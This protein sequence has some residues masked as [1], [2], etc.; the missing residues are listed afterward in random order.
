[1]LWLRAQTYRSTNESHPD[2]ASDQI[3]YGRRGKS[4]QECAAEV[5]RQRKFPIAFEYLHGRT[6]MQLL[7]CHASTYELDFFA[8]HTAIRIPNLL[9]GSKIL[10][11]YKV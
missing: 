10:L 9:E 6:D 11:G 8:Y 4:C 2:Q 5:E 3:F 1:M 7:M